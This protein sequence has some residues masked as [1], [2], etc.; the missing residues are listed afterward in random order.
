[1]EKKSQPIRDEYGCIERESDRRDFFKRIAA[2][3]AGMMAVSSVKPTHANSFPK[4]TKLNP[5]KMPKI[6]LGGV[7]VSRLIMGGNPIGG[8]S[9][10][11]RML[12]DIMKEWYTDDRIL[13]LLHHAE[14]CGI[15]TWQT[16]LGKELADV[17]L[18]YKREGGKMNLIVLTRLDDPETIKWLATVKPMALI[19]HGEVTDI[20]WR[21]GRIDTLIPQLEA[22]RNAGMKVAVSTHNPDCLRYMDKHQ[23]DVDFF[24][25]CF[26]EISKKQKH[27][28]ED[29][30]WQPLH[31]VYP[32]PAPATMTAAVRDVSKPCLGFKILAAGR[33]EKEEAIEQAYKF[34]FDNIKQ[35]DGVIVGMFPKFSD[36]IAEGARHTVQYGRV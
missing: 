6:K 33:V 19:H 17:W 13:E 12:S 9:H 34:A 27:W 31:E 20:M 21:E 1:M 22:V 35:T 16:G 18:R 4:E 14:A 11:G 7:P 28:K 2:V 5:G 15:T 3:S 32:E 29:L 26:Y 10:R 36:Q 24:L 25:T 8:Y 23:W 30:G